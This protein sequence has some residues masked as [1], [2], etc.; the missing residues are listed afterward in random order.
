AYPDTGLVHTPHLGRETILD[1]KRAALEWH[2]FGW[3]A[4]GVMFPHVPCLGGGKNFVVELVRPGSNELLHVVVAPLAVVNHV[5]AHVNRVHLVRRGPLHHHS[6]GWLTARILLPDGNVGAVGD[7]SL[8]RPLIV[9]LRCGE[10]SFL[11]VRVETVKQRVTR[12]K[13]VRRQ[14]RFDVRLRNDSAN[15]NVHPLKYV[16]DVE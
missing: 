13:I 6:A 3:M 12:H 14:L 10:N 7:S 16:W 4:D 5:I 15:S 8:D 11:T 2:V 1:L 9:D